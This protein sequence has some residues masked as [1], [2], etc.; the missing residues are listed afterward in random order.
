MGSR[1]VCMLGVGSAPGAHPKLGTA[2]FFLSFLFYY[3]I[4][5]FFRNRVSLCSPSCPGTCSVDE[6]GLELRDPPAF[7]F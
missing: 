2:D 7:F 3:F 5:C 4:F 6:A 1:A